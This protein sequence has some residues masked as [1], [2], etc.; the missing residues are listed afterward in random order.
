[1]V[2][3]IIDYGIEYNYEHKIKRRR[4]IWPWSWLEQYWIFVFVCHSIHDLFPGTWVDFAQE[5]LNWIQALKCPLANQQSKPTQFMF[6][7]QIK[8]APLFIFFSFFLTVWCTIGANEMHQKITSVVFQ[9]WNVFATMREKKVLVW[10]QVQE[11]ICESTC[12]NQVTLCRAVLINASAPPDTPLLAPSTWQLGHSEGIVK[13]GE[14][15]GRKHYSSTFALI[16]WHNRKTLEFSVNWRCCSASTCWPLHC[17][18]RRK[19]VFFM[20]IKSPHSVVQH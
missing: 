2:F 17:S 7:G 9:C 3:L 5:T 6:S 20:F 10:L 13:I 14:L 12:S 4:T 16:E 1:M 8:C 18:L 19:F 11:R 15:S